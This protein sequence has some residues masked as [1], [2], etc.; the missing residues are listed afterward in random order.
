[1]IF[2]ATSIYNPRKY[3]INILSSREV[4]K[5]NKNQDKSCSKIQ[6]PGA[7][8]YENLCFL[9][10]IVGQKHCWPANGSSKSKKGN[11][12]TFQQDSW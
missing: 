1:M 8:C 2:M 12:S 10:Y 11:I 7:M 9:G 4:K 6:I 5:Q 3:K